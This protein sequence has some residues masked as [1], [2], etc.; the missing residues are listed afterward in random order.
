VRAARGVSIPV[1]VEL[2]EGLVPA[3]DAT[4]FVFAR[5]VGGP[6]MPLVVARLTAAEL[7]TVVTLDDSMAMMPGRG[8]AAAER[9][10]LVARVTRSGGVSAAPG[11]LEGSAGPVTPA[12]AGR[13][14][15]LLIDRVVE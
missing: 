5:E 3:P 11:D 12:A 15:P 4:V 14:V 1:L 7:P 10:E 2:A 8:L 6:P 13:V 9:V